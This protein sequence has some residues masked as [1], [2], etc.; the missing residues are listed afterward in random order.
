MFSVDDLNF[1]SYDYIP[2]PIVVTHDWDILY[3]NDEAKQ[4]FQIQDIDNKSL[5]DFLNGEQKNFFK[6]QVALIKP[7]E[8]K[9]F[10]IT[11]QVGDQLIPIICLIKLFKDQNNN[12]YFFIVLQKIEAFEEKFQKLSKIIIDTFTLF[13]K[14]LFKTLLKKLSEE[15]KISGTFIYVHN[16]NLTNQ[17]KFLYESYFQDNINFNIEDYRFSEKLQKRLDKYGTIIVEKSFS[18]QY[19][20]D[21]LAKENIEVFIGIKINISKDERLYIVAFSKNPIND[22]NELHFTL[23]VCSVKI[24]SEY[25]RENYFLKYENFYNTFLNTNDAVFLYH[26][27]SDKIIDCN[28]AFY[29]LLNLTSQEVL[30]KSIFALLG[31]SF[32]KRYEKIFKYSYKT[33]KLKSGKIRL[34]IKNSLGIEIPV[35]ASIT[36]IKNKGETLILGIMRDLTFAIQAVEEHKKYLQTLSLLQL[37]VIEL[38]EKLNVLYIN[39][40]PN[41]K[42]PNLNK[43]SSFLEVILEDYREYVKTVL[44]NVFKTKKSI[45]IRF[46][47][48]IS[49]SRNDWYEAD[50]VL[51]RTKKKKYIRG[52]IKDITLEYISEK[53]FILLSEHDLLTSLPNR[54]RL[55]EDLYKAILRADKNR[56]LIAVGF[57]DLDKFF[58]VNELLGHRFGDLVLSLFSEKLQQIPEINN[59]LYRWGGDQF[60]FFVEN[61]KNK[62]DIHGLLEKLRRLAKEP[63]MI[64][65]EK[66]FITFSIGISIYPIDGMTIDTLF[67]EADKAMNFAK[68]NGRFQFVFA[69]NLP[70]KDTTI[71]KFEIQSH[72]LESISENKILP[73]FQPIYEIRTNRI[74][75]ME[76]LARLANYRG[77]IYIGPDIFIPLAEDLGLI[78]ELSYYIIKKSLEFYKKVH[79]KYGI[80][81][82]INISRR[83]LH[84]DLFI[85][86]MF[87]LQRELGINP[88]GVVIEVTES[89]AFLDKDSSLKKLYQLREM[90]YRIAIDDFGTGYSSLGELQEL[91]I[92]L[93]KIDKIFVR[94]LKSEDYNRI[95]DA[96]VLLAQNLNLE[97]IAEGV[98]DLETLKKLDNMGIK[99]AQG[100]FYAPPLTEEDFVKRIENE[101]IKNYHYFS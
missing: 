74:A 25:L 22:V 82:S 54:N 1:S 80:Y 53:Q 35:E 60:V 11:L 49:K 21:L 61:I 87:N 64:E 86:N 75:G 39:Y 97:L 43:N 56:T 100:F 94:R 89:L 19:P 66:Y 47:I 59:T 48:K 73:Y 62:S 90:G 15:F 23:N 83:A 42:F 88:K 68:Q 79:E 98:E 51:I 6:F 76:A 78:E 41:S 69:S 27:E 26:V 92:D 85:M 7:E 71:S 32:S 72:I 96:I 63:I 67:G 9:S 2:L 36:Y 40:I 4:V 46:P 50:F 31:D 18:T 101:E 81:L 52:I 29:K 5:L 77:G 37:H 70:R 38:D 20:E 34:F 24:V 3:A 95:L 58:Y 45:R 10:S 91:P 55:E 14:A 8:L 84:S 30:N 44:E 65:G 12:C 28:P 16:E 17:Q 99:Y 13:G 57:L 33:N 93:I